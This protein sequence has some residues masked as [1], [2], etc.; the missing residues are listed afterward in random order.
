MSSH[1]LD[2][3]K[4]PIRFFTN[5]GINLLLTEQE[6]MKGRKLVFAAQVVSAEHLTSQQGKP[7]GKVKLE[8]QQATIDL[9]VFAETYLKCKH[10]L[11]TGTFVMVTAILQPSYRDKDKLEI[12]VQEM[13]LLDNVVRIHTKEMNITLRTDLMDNDS[14]QTFIALFQEY[15]GK[16]P[17][18]V[19]L[20]DQELN[21]KTKLHSTKKG[22]DLEHLLPKLEQFDWLD[23]ELK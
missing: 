12:R 18:T 1:P 14:V 23:L 15:A 17:Y 9:M 4:I 10:L 2:S 19:T 16:F 8:D 20:E 5:S 22:V 11:D 3:Y 7:Y 6:S 21:I 13:E